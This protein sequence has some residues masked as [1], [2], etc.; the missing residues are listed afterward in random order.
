MKKE[1]IQKII[2]EVGFCSRRKAEELI[3]KNRVM[4]NG[5]KVNLGDKADF[6]DVITIDGEHIKLKRN[7]KKIYIMLYKP[8]GYVSTMSDDRGRRCVA[9]LVKDLSYRVYPIGRLDVNSEGLLLFTNDGDFANK[10]MHPSSHVN[11]TYRVTIRPDITD[12]QVA[13]LSEGVYIDG[14]KTAPALVN[15]LSKES[16]RV[17]VEMI[18]SEGRNRQIRKMMDSVRV[19]VVRLKRTSIGPIK[20]GM[21]KPGRWRELK[22]DELSSL[23]NE[24]KNCFDK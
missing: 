10:I 1:R 2:A 21:L 8:R 4:C 12:E 24:V 22:S 9:D 3:S 11:K 17:V 15:I 20:L 6:N 19:R 14:K 18:I 23:K 5:R 13:K 16:N 7:K